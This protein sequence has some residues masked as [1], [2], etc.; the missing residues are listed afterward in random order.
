MY[1]LTYIDPDGV[2]T[3]RDVRVL[4]IGAGGIIRAMCKLRGAP[5][6]FRIDRV[7]E[8]LCCDSG[9]VF[10]QQQFTQELIDKYGRNTS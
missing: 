3:W 10:T 9:E 1:R 2:I 6:S 7:K 4:G 8:A 5:R